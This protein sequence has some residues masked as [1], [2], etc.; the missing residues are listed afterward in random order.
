MNYSNAPVHDPLTGLYNRS[1]FFNRIGQLAERSDAE[2]LLLA[3]VMLDIDHFKGINDRYGHPLGDQALRDVAMVI[4]ES[5]R[6]EDIVARYGGEEF[7]IALA[8]S[9]PRLASE[10]AERIRSNVAGGEAIAGEN[11]I[12]I[13][14]SLGMAYGPSRRSANLFGLDPDG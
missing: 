14:A 7:V 1:Y 2:G 6:P 13:T 12:R 5:T 9:T 11:D 4:R 8:V 10:I 3:V